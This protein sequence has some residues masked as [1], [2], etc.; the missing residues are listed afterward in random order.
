[1]LGQ[2]LIDPAYP[3]LKRHAGLDLESIQLAL[4]R[5]FGAI[6]SAGLGPHPTPIYCWVA[7]P[8]YRFNPCLNKKEG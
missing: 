4:I 5:Q 7:D 1:V 3:K 8:A 2:F 6:I